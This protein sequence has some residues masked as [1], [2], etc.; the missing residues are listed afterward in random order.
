MENENDSL[1]IDKKEQLKSEFIAVNIEIVS[2]QE[3]IAILQEKLNNK[4]M[5]K[6]RIS[7][8]FQYLD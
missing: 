6:N 4:I 7:Y 8:A 3:E 5:E 1:H 2:I